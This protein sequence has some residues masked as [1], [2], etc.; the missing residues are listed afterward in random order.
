MVTDKIPSL[1]FKKSNINHKHDYCQ[2]LNLDK[3]DV[4]LMNRYPLV[5]ISDH[6]I[7]IRLIG[8]TFI[9]RPPRWYLL[10]PLLHGTLDYPDC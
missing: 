9:S 5:V 1:L 3:H 2:G 6:E 4:L 8:L 10:K 7:L